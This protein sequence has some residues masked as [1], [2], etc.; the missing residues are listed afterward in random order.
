MK[1]CRLPSGTCSLHCGNSENRKVQGTARFM[2]SLPPFIPARVFPLIRRHI[3]G[4][5]RGA[6]LAFHCPARH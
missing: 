2:A 4:R 3:P 5:R 6:L 1:P